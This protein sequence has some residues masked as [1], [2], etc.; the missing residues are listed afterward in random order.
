MMPEEA[1][2]RRAVAATLRTVAGWGQLS[3]VTD[4]GEFRG[5]NVK[6][7]EMYELADAVENAPTDD[8]WSC[9]LCQESECDEGCPLE[10]LRKP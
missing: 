10:P 5:V 8:W 7:S 4:A 1:V 3:C 2:L 6:T 9:P